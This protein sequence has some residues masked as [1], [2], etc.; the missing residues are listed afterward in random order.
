MACEDEGKVL[1]AFLV[2]GLLGAGLALL[3][4]PQSGERTRKD[5]SK[6]SKKV[7]EGAVERGEDT[8]ESI[9]NL[10]DEIGEKISDVASKGKEL[11]E[12]TKKKILKTIEDGQR[13]IEKQKSKLSKLI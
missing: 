13:I 2:G 9:V 7:K 6:F 4:A 8:V 11:S 12:D 10:A 3:F 5:I 1:G